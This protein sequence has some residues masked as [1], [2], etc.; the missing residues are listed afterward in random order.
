MTFILE[1]IIFAAEYCSQ[2]V[3]TS[4]NGT[5]SYLFGSKW[6][7]L[8]CCINTF[9]NKIFVQERHR[10]WEHVWATLPQ[11]E[12]CRRRMCFLPHPIIYIYGSYFHL[13]LTCY[14]LYTQIINEK[15][16]MFD[17]M[18]SAYRDNNYTEIALIKLQDD[19]LSALDAG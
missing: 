7:V 15:S 3:I 5:L 11:Y 13:K 6:D 17:L 9:V 2:M 16:S 1:E 4:I 10:K 14:Y 18:Q 8:N 12:K 19:I